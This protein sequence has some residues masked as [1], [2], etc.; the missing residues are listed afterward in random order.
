MSDAGQWEDLCT[1]I[2][3]VFLHLEKIWKKYQ[4]LCFCTQVLT[5]WW[6][7]L[8]A[9]PVPTYAILNLDKIQ[10]RVSILFII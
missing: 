9:C 1:H 2:I 5:T 8:Y 7:H 10:Y 6:L 3:Y 4:L